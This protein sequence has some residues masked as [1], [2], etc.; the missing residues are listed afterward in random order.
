MVL[1]NFA[2]QS[3]AKCNSGVVKL[4]KYG[5][6]RKVSKEMKHNE[7]ILHYFQHGKWYIMTQNTSKNLFLC[8]VSI[9]IVVIIAVLWDL[10]T[11]GAN[12]NACAAYFCTLYIYAL[13]SR[14]PGMQLC[15]LYIICRFHLIPICKSH[16]FSLKINRKRLIIMCLSMVLVKKLT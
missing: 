11:R 7:S 14:I 13:R 6:K 10:M 2:P 5:Q 9:H 16:V 1:F 3:V 12:S 15:T 4:P 8:P